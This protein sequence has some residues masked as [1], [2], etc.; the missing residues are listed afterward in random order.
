MIQSNLFGHVR[1]AFTG[2]HDEKQGLFALADGGTIFLDEIGDA[3]AEL[4]GKLLRAIERKSFKK[5]GDVRDVRVDVRVIAATNKDLPDRARQGKFRED[6]FYRLNVIPI[7][8]PPL[9]NRSEDIP[10]LVRRLFEKVCRQARK[11]DKQLTDETLRALS[12]H[13]WPGNI[14]ELE[15]ALRHAVAFCDRAEIRPDHLPP[16]ARNAPAEPASPAGLGGPTGQVVDSDALREALS[17]TPVSPP[18]HSYQ[19]PGHVDYAR[20]AY[21]KALIERYGGDLRDIARHWDRSS[22]HTLRK[23]I[24][25]L[26]LLEHLQAARAQRK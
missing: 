25:Q 16:T 10:A 5:L 20:R 13:H 19:W 9:R 18:A 8:L 6:L 2:A 23:Q 4:Q 24:R 14:R 26:G 17:A 11:Q 22:E 7:T 3:S 21:L 1:G 12:A 15:N